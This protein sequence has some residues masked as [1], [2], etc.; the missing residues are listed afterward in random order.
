M[1][2]VKNHLYD[3][4]ALWPKQNF[5]TLS[6]KPMSGTIIWA[7]VFQF[8][9]GENYGY[10][11]TRCPSLFLHFDKWHCTTSAN[12]NANNYIYSG[13]PIPMNVFS[14]F[15]YEQRFNATIQ[16]YVIKVFI[17]NTLV[18]EVINNDARD[19]QNVKIYLANSWYDPAD[20]IVKDFKYGIL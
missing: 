2:L 19:F 1:N 10:H 17:N 8:T 6:I 4:I 13:E 15:Y 3:I 7:N 5:V 16:E 14:Y 9:T 11:G 12:G 20:A 18:K